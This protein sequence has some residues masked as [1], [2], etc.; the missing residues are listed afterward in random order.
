MPHYHVASFFKSFEGSLML[1]RPTVAPMP[2]A[3][4]QLAPSLAPAALAM[5]CGQQR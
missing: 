3:I 4:T 2:T 1:S 5:S